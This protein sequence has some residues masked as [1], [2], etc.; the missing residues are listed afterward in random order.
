MESTFRSSLVPGTLQ[1]KAFQPIITEL[2]LDGD[3]LPSPEDFLLFLKS[4]C[5]PSEI[6]ISGETQSNGPY[7]NTIS[8]KKVRRDSNDSPPTRHFCKDAY[9]GLQQS[10][11]TIEHPMV[12]PHWETYKRY[13]NPYELVYVS[14]LRN[15]TKFRSIRRHNP[16]S[17]AYYKMIEMIVSHGLC[18][19]SCVNPTS[20]L[21]L[22]EGPGGFVQALCDVRTHPNDRFVGI[23]LMDNVDWIPAWKR[24]KTSR[25]NDSRFHICYG[26]DNTGNLLNPNHV[27]DLLKCNKKKKYDL[28]TGDGGFDFSASFDTQEDDAFSLIVS[29]VFYMLS[30]QKMGGHAVLKLFDTFN[31]STV[32]LIALLTDCYESVTITKPNT[33]RP[34]NSERY[35][36][37]KNFKGVLDITL[38]ALYL[39]MTAQCFTHCSSFMGITCFPTLLKWLQTYTQEFTSVQQNIIKDTVQAILL[40]SK[41]TKEDVEMMKQTVYESQESIATHWYD[42]MIEHIRRNQTIDSCNNDSR[43]GHSLG[44]IS[45]HTSYDWAYHHKIE[46]SV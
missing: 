17:R 46:E 33:S 16:L 5:N 7:I 27:N 25:W 2:C 28:I 29:Q 3:E 9:E 18:D 15:A 10:K 6:S 11:R 8:P 14:S 1:Q 35:L 13:T 19:L 44:N 12:A 41:Q 26:Y 30:C 20:T 39:G 43:T 31:R 38:E 4:V 24:I 42:T 45:S 34:A 40:H 21:H 32:Q 36:I 37:C 23:T 22:C